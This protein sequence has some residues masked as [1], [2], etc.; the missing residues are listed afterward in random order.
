MVTASSIV[1]ALPHCIGDLDIVSLQLPNVC[2]NVYNSKDGMRQSTPVPEEHDILQDISVNDITLDI[3]TF[4]PNDPSH[5]I[6]PTSN[7]HLNTS[8]LTIVSEH[9][10]DPTSPAQFYI[11]FY[12][13]LAT[14]SIV[15]ST[16]T[17][18]PQTMPSTPHPVHQQQQTQQLVQQQG[19]GVHHLQQPVHTG[20][21]SHQAVTCFCH[22]KSSYL[23]LSQK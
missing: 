15:C 5:Y 9:Q 18:S 6:A 3:R 2:N 4:N 17:S 14:S 13:P 20:A 16:T 21:H 11:D 10:L 19:H 1:P 22:R 23:L 7:V 8:P 12:I